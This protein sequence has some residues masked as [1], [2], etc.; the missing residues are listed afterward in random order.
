MPD[1]KVPRKH[2]GRVTF[3]LTLE[4]LNVSKRKI[5]RGMN[6]RSDQ[7]LNYYMN[8]RDMRTDEAPAMRIAK[9]KPGQ[10][11]SLQKDLD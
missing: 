6:W 5:I 2:S 11:A 10:L 4:K 1:H 9:L 8:R 3:V 7:M